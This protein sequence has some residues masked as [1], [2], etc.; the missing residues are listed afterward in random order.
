MSYAMGWNVQDYRGELLV[1][2]AG[3]LNGFRTHVALLP[4]RN[5]GFVLMINAGR[6]MVARTR[7]ATRSIDMLSGKPSPRLERL[8]PD[9]RPRRRREGGEGQGRSASR[10]RVP[11]TTP[12]RPL[13]D[14]AG[15][16]DERG[17]RPG[18]G[19]ARRRRPRAAVE[20]HHRAARRTST[21]T[22]ST[23]RRRST[24]SRRR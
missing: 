12:T 2:H 7:C 9:A 17:L 11:N 14:Y 18:E 1:S 3:S 24:R 5:A 21:T 23:P 20:P 22:S 19:L 6:G 16:Y 4:K 13:A 8:L 15:E 10:K